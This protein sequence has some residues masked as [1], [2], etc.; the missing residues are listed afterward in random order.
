[1]KHLQYFAIF[2]LVIIFSCLFFGCSFLSNSLN[3]IE[4]LRFIQNM[5]PNYNTQDTCSKASN[6][7]WVS[8]EAYPD[9]RCTYD[10]PPENTCMNYGTQ[11]E[12]DKP[13]NNCGWLT[14]EA[15]PKGLC[16]Y[17]PKE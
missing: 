3:N 9:G 15:Y 5:C 11:D 16:A 1:M 14:N 6:C 7:M 8:N 17:S 2:L 13:N 4:H 12:C 10:T